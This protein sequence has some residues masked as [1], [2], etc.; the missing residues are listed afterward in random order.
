MSQ[1]DSVIIAPPGPLDGDSQSLAHLQPAWEE[2]EALVRSQ[3]IAAIGTS[4]L[5][6]DMLEQLYNWAQVSRICICVQYVGVNVDLDSNM[7]FEQCAI[8]RM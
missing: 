5:D 2:L 4:D 7:S 8:D 6:K 3:R 1:L